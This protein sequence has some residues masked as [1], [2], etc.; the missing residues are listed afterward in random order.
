MNENLNGKPNVE[1]RE[2]N[3]VNQVLIV[4]ISNIEPGEEIFVD[5]GKEV[6]RTGWG[7]DKFNNYAK[8]FSNG[9]PNAIKTQDKNIDNDFKT[10]NSNN[11]NE[12]MITKIVMIMIMIMIMM[13]MKIVIIKIMIVK[14]ILMIIQSKLIV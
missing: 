13:I 3:Q 4:A 1:F 12:K 9:N 2:G 7:S 5:Y 14:V 11:N 10:N 8:N 6:D